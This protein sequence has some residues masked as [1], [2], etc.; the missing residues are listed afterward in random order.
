M[1]YLTRFSLF[2]VCLMGLSFF[3]FNSEASSTSSS[4]SYH[5]NKEKRKEKEK[6]DIEFIAKSLRDSENELLEGRLSH[7]EKGK[8]KEGESKPS[9]ES[10]NRNKNPKK[11]YSGNLSL[12]KLTEYVDEKML[13]PNSHD[14]PEIHMAEYG[15]LE[16]IRHIIALERG[17]CSDET[18]KE[19]EHILYDL[20]LH[21]ASQGNTDPIRALLISRLKTKIRYSEKEILLFYA[22]NLARIFHEPIAVTF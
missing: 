4:L 6:E 17:C 1:N 9:I 20:L 16:M 11:E 14:I 3:H 5:V 12:S 18:R 15:Q 7:G 2:S 21:F 19:Y 8:E 22:I 10:D 13:N